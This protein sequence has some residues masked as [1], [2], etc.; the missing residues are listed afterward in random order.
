MEQIN[1][2]SGDRIIS[3]IFAGSSMEGLER[4]L[5]AYD[6]VF[7]V[8]DRAVAM[9]CPSAAVV[10]EMMNRRGAPGMLVFKSILADFFEQ[11]H[12]AGQ[13]A[14]FCAQDLRKDAARAFVE[15]MLA[16]FGIKED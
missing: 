11:M 1:I 16:Q 12:K 9:E 3:S 13:M 10:A 6:S 8:M 7:V 5:E 4:C 15:R 2:F 14:A